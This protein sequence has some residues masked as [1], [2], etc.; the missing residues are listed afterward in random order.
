MKQIIETY[1]RKR[2]VAMH[3][4]GEA[5]QA[6]VYRCQ[7]CGHLATWNDIR[8][9]RVCCQGHVIPAVPTWPETFKLLLWPTKKPDAPSEHV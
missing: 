5:H 6:D 2:F 7:T 9:A 8:S 3:G 1:L 4:E